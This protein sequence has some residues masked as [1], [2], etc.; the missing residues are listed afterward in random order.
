M[1]RCS[2]CSGVFDPTAPIDDPAVEAGAFM[3]RELFADTGELCP[4]CLASRGV[5]GMMYCRELD[6]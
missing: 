4:K 1:K 5:L 3:A 2:V 6:G